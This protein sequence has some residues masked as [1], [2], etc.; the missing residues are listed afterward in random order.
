M[1]GLSICPAKLIDAETEADRWRMRANDPWGT[2]EV[3][4]EDRKGYE[5]SLAK[6]SVA[7]CDA[8]AA[9]EAEVNRRL[10]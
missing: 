5:E 7:R 6:L 1:S 9:C 3:T 2:R 10:A 4:E 8:I